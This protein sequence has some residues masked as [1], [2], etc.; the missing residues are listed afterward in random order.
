MTWSEAVLW[1]LGGG[2]TLGAGLTD[3]SGFLV[4]G[5]LQ[6]VGVLG[7]GIGAVL[8]GCWRRGGATR[9][10]L[11]ALAYLGTA[12]VTS[13]VV[14]G[15][16]A[17]DV[18]VPLYG[19]VAVVAAMHMRPVVA[20]RHLVVVVGATALLVGLGDLAPGRAAILLS[21]VI[22]VAAVVSEVRTAQARAL[23]ECERQETWR[24][25]MIGALAHDIRSPLTVVRGVLATVGR[26]PDGLDDETREQLLAI[27]DRHAS[28]IQSL[29]DDLLA[30][31]R[32]RHGRLALE[33]STVVA[34]DLV[35]HATAAHGGPVEVDVPDDLVLWGDI[36]RLTQVLLNLLRNAAVHGEPPVELTARAVDD[37]VR[38]EVRDHGPGVPPELTEELFEGFTRGLRPDSVGLGL[39]IVRML[40]EAHGGRVDHEQADPGARFAVWLP[41]APAPTASVARRPSPARPDVG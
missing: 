36:D 24:A 35:G 13:A 41:S 37:G 21:V 2:I 39:W 16:P 20:V 14:A 27:A 3:G 5:Y 38:L 11:G 8:V 1:L 9:P 26:D 32:V 34:A 23:D 25:A 15:G 10:V 22:V 19:F 40:V 31:E 28:R 12:L 4:P 33:P 17:G 30:A 29:S 6:T 18:F 7:M